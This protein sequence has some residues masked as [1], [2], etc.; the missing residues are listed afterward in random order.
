MK[1]W[2][3]HFYYEDGRVE[4]GDGLSDYW[5]YVQAIEKTRDSLIHLFP[6]LTKIT[7][8]DNEGTEWYSIKL[9]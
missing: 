1:M 9:R 3:T 6:D 2:Y 4:K 5:G 7:L 8:T